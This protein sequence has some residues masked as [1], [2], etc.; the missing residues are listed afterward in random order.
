MDVK[1][2]CAAALGLLMSVV[3]NE[4]GGEALQLATRDDLVLAGIF[5]LCG[6]GAGSLLP[7]YNPAIAAKPARY[8]LAIATGVVFGT[9]GGGLAFWFTSEL[10][11]SIA[12]CI[13]AATIG[14]VFATDPKKTTHDIVAAFRGKGGAA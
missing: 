3:A 5:V 10:W 6:A 9:L 8:V 2:A 7:A 4:A 14:P 1:S 11:P 13:A 12:A